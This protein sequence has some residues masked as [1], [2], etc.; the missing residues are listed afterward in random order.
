MA[1]HKS[2]GQEP[3]AAAMSDHQLQRLPIAS[4]VYGS[5]VTI[6]FGCKLPVNQV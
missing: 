3:C 5:I 6:R 4:C 2:T 1:D